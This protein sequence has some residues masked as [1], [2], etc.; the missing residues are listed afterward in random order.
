MLVAVKLHAGILSAAANVPF[1]LLE[2]QPKCRDFAL[3]IG[4]QDFAPRTDEINEAVLIDRVSALIEH[5]D[6][7]KQELCSRMCALMHRFEDYCR[8][9]EPLLTKRNSHRAG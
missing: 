8:Q 2:Y 3:S 6:S 9:I 5:L 7:K 1:V 4:W